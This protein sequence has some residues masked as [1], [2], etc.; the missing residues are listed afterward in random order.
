MFREGRG[1]LAFPAAPTEAGLGRGGG[2]IAQPLCSHPEPRSERSLRPWQPGA[3]RRELE[4]LALGGTEGGASAHAHA[5]SRG[6]GGGRP[7]KGGG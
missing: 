2:K 7:D 3:Q 5:E 4:S 1:A 6:R